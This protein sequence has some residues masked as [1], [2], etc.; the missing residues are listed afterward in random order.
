[1]RKFLIL[2]MALLSVFLLHTSVYAADT[3]NDTIKIGLYYGSGA[4]QSI[5]IGS[6]SGFTLGSEVDGVFTPSISVEETEVTV[7]ASADGGINVGQYTFLPEQFPTL[8]PVSGNI[9]ID[10][11]EY[12]GGA[13]FKRINGGA[14][15]VIN[16]VNLEEYLYSVIG[17]EMS[18]SWNIEA[19]KAQAV[20]ARGFAISNKN[21]FARYGFNLDNT[22]SS[23]VYKG[24]ST[25]AESTRRAVDE[26]RGTVLMYDGGIIESIYCSCTGGATAN[27]ENVWGGKYPYLVSVVDIYENPEEVSRYSWSITLT[28]DEIKECLAGADVNIGDIKNVKIISSDDAGYVCELLFEGT[29]GTHTVKRSSCRTIFGGKLHS[30]RYTIAG[31]EDVFENVTVLSAVGAANIESNNLYVLGAGESSSVYVKS[32]TDIK[33]YKKVSSPYA[34]DGEFTFNGN[35][36]GHGVGMSQWGAKA[37]ADMGFTYGDILTFYYTGTYLEKLY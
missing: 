10:G 8:Y 27:A 19:L 4:K 36:W 23:Q 17:K 25:E 13:Q 29:G 26:T 1:M 24:V 37:M 5:V 9:T 22:T 14:L 16:V 32:A 6:V 30:Q 2:T 15:T 20:C 28:A 34:K 35:G 12:R 18:P 21:K 33:E 31:G 7:T 11:A 3:E